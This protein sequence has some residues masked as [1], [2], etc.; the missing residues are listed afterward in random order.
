MK[1][2]LGG[3]GPVDMFDAIGIRRGI[4]VGSIW[5]RLIV[6]STFVVVICILACAIPF[7]GE[8]PRISLPSWDKYICPMRK[9]VESMQ[10]IFTIV[11]TAMPIV[12]H[13]WERDSLG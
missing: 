9:R 6:R 5:W 11:H 12:T 3:G 13:A 10:S 4:N 2:S 1:K 7:F 8:C